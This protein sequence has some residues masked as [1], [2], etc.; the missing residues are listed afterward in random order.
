M[1]SPLFEATVN[2]I[3]ETMDLFGIDDEEFVK[4]LHHYFEKLMDKIIKGRKDK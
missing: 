4:C 1:I 3:Q 2:R